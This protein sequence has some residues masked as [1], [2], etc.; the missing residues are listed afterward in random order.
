MV[1]ENEYGNRREES[2]VY[3]A[4][5][6]LEESSDRINWKKIWDVFKVYGVGR[7]LLSDVELFYKNA[8]ACGKVNGEL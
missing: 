5:I 6:D 2:T 8:D 7:K 1:A 4:F 3:A